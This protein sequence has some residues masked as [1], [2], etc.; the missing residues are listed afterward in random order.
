VY[1]S[2]YTLGPGIV[3]SCAVIAIA[4]LLLWERK[5][6]RLPSYV[7]GTS[8]VL[9]GMVVSAWQLNDAW[10]IVFYVLHLVPAAAVVIFAWAVRGRL[11]AHEAAAEDARTIEEAAERERTARPT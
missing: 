9:S 1:E 3:I 10:P 7:I 4:H 11:A 6:P 2:P 8:A 5:I